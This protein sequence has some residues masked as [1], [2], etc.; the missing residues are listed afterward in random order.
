MRV[1]AYIKVMVAAMPLCGASL[2]ANYP[3]QLDTYPFAPS[4]GSDGSSSIYK[5]DPSILAWASGYL[6]IIYGTGVSDLWRTPEKALGSP[7]ADSFD[8]VSLG[9]GGQITLTFDAAISDGSGMDFA[10]YENSFSDTF[11]EL[12]WVEVSTDGLHFVRF[13]NFSY[14]ANPV[15]SF[16][17]VDPT[18]IHG[19]AGKYK[20]SYG[21]PFDLKQLQFAYDA[22]LRETDSFANEYETSLRANFPYLNLAEINYVRLVDIVGDGNSRD[23]EGYAI[24]EPYPTSG[25]AGFDLDAVAVIHQVVQSKLS[26]IINFDP[27]SSQLISD[28]F[29]TLQAESSSDLTVEFAVIDG[30]AS[31]DGNRLFFDGSG[32]VILSASQQ[33]DSTYLAATPVTRSFVIADDLQH[34]FLQPVANHSVNSENILLQAISSSGL[35]VSISLDSSP[36]GTSMSEFAPY[37]LKTGNQTG[38]ATVRA[39]QPGG[40]LNGVTYAPAQDISLRFKI[41]SANDA[42]VGLRY[43]SWKDLHQLSSDNNFDSDLDGQTDFEEYVAGTDPNSSTSVSRHSYQIDAHQCTFSIVLSAQAL[44]SLQVQHCSNLSDENDWMSIAPQ[45]EYVTLNDPSM[46]TSQNIKLKVDR[47]F[48]PSNFWRVVF[49]ELD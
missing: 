13:P 29:I 26:Q 5:N 18:Y 46:V 30:P 28:S 19:F 14:T 17:N 21:T 39:T 42:N 34:I 40:T 33:G 11:L 31:I 20:Q 32:T 24:Y 1:T 47:T 7:N 2:L 6:D 36:S 43:D 37:L 22:V 10:I 15:G 25:S 9:R 38:F 49:S 4:A 12:A 23:A 48:S 45:V 16:G 27:I 41:V 3:G 44:I 35:P 8:I